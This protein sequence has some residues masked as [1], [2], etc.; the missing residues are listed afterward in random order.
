MSSLIE[1]RHAYSHIIV[2]GAEGSPEP[3]DADLE[4]MVQS[5]LSPILVLGKKGS[6]FLRTSP[7][8]Q[9][10]RFI[11]NENAHLFLPALQAALRDLRHPCFYW[12]YF[13]SEPLANYH[14]ELAEMAQKFH[15]RMESAL[16]GHV[17][18]NPS[19]GWI[20]LQGMTL[21]KSLPSDLDVWQF[22]GFKISPFISSTKG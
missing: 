15:P 11:F 21:F 8:A 9:T 12:S 7:V 19:L 2:L 13:G 4:F 6:E 3:V 17:V 5:R 22:L 14:K 20:T 16:P 18:G 10:T 1:Y